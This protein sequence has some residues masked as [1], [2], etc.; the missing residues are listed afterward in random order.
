MCWRAP[1]PIISSSATGTRPPCLL[2][3]RTCVKTADSAIASSCRI[4][5]CRSGGKESEILAMVE[6]T[7]VVCRVE[8]TRWPV[9]AAATAIRMVSGSRI[10]PTTMMSGACRKAA[11][12][13]VGKSG[14]STPISTCST[15]LRKWVCSY[16]RG[17]SMVIMWRASRRL[18]SLTKA[19]TV[20]DFPAPA[21]P[22]MRTRP[23]GN[24]DKTST[25]AGRC[26]S[27]SKGTRTGR[28]RTAAA[29]LP[30]SR[31][32]L[33]RKRPTPDTR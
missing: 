1:Y 33:I 22:P 27:S 13:A 20:V 23:L 25:A 4:V 9:S 8:S 16:S 30:R 6:A 21:G 2:G 14:A 11:R 19:A 12:S 15:T 28:A 3:R 29:A 17:S 10:S 7:S 31:C 5:G 32:R 18:I 24:F 26:N